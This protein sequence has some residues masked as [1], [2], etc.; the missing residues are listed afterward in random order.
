LLGRE[1]TVKNKGIVTRVVLVVTLLSITVTASAH[2]GSAGGFI[3]GRNQFDLDALD[4]ALGTR[5]FDALESF[6]F[7]TGLGGYKLIN[8]K[9]I[10]GGEIQSSEQTLFNDSSKA[11][12]GVSY[13]MFNVGY[14]VFQR[15]T[16]RAFPL[17]GIGRGGVHLRMVER[18]TTPTFDEVLTRPF[19]ESNT[20]AGGLVLQA[21]VG[22]D[23]FLKFSQDRHSRGGL[24]FGTRIGYTYKP[25]EA[26][27]KMGDRDVLGG[28]DVDFSGIFVHFLMGGGRFDD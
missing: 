7:S 12:V 10:I 2:E 13:V 11:S 21:A 23:Y 14:V 8:G 15:K 28:P 1:K 20:G 24:L 22:I 26:S 5:G 19:R 27:W 6:D 18:A 3:F 17:L 9:L 4:A 25:T 16:L